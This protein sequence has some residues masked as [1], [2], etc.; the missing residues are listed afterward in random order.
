MCL[1][2]STDRQAPHDGIG[3]CIESRGKNYVG[4]SYFGPLCSHCLQSKHLGEHSLHHQ[5]HE[6][7][8][9]HLMVKLNNRRRCSKTQIN[10][11]TLKLQSNGP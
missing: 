11:G 9:N 8:L 2:I 5:Q 7:Y 4:N 10:P 6:V 3:R 1:L